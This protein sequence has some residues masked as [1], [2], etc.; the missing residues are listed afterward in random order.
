LKSTKELLIEGEIC[1]EKNIHEI[2]KFLQYA[3]N[4]HGAYQKQRNIFEPFKHIYLIQNEFKDVQKIPKF[5]NNE[6]L[7]ILI[8]KSANLIPHRCFHH[9]SNLITFH[10]FAYIE[11]LEESCFEY[12]AGL[13]EVLLP[14]SLKK[15]DRK[16]FIYCGSLCKINI[17]KSMNEIC[18]ECFYRTALFFEREEID[19]E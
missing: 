16:C 6:T 7:A 15:I 11:I 12:C 5:D 13:K 17:P 19:I 8:S 18:F 14:E 3:W 2:S 4:P 9:F 10:I 1:L